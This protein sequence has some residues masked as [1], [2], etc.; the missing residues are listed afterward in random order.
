MTKKPEATIRDGAIKATIW[1]ETSEKG[2]YF[3][4]TLTRT[5]KDEKTGDYRESGSFL[6]T[7]LLKVS[8][9]AA[10][11][12]QQGRALRQESYKSPNKD[13]EQ[14]RDD[15]REQAS[16]TAEELERSREATRDR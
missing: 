14:A 6:G 3:P 12:Y 13:V 10:E 8:S 15:Y 9:L 16:K 1:R 11:A 5:Y 7:D 2:D 4:T